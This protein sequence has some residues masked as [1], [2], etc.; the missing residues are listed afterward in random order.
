MRPVELEPV[1]HGA[2]QKIVDR[3]AQGLR[4][5]V[6]Q[7]V[8]DRRDG[9]LVEPAMGLAR[10]RVELL[11]DA[12]VAARVVAGYGLDQR[13]DDRGQPLGA[14]ALVVFRDAGDALVGLQFQKREVAPSGV[15]VQ[16]FASGNFHFTPSR[17]HPPKSHID[18]K[19]GIT[20]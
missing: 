18:V 7:G 3:H 8:L 12:L 17:L 14:V 11:A 9:L 10:H 19:V 16:R 20:E 2:A 4:L 6:E 5:E 13:L 15:A 1:A